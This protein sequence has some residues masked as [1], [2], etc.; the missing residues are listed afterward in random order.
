[1]DVTV[2]ILVGSL[3]Q[4]S[5]QLVLVVVA[6]SE[7]VLEDR[8]V[9]GVEQESGKPLVMPVQETA[10]GLESGSDELFARYESSLEYIADGLGITPSI[11]LAAGIA[12]RA[13]A[14]DPFPCPTKPLFRD[15]LVLIGKALEG[16]VSARDFVIAHDAQ[17]RDYLRVKASIAF[18]TKTKVP[19]PNHWVVL[20]PD[21]RLLTY[22]KVLGE[23]VHEY[24][25]ALE[26]AVHDLVFT[27]VLDIGDTTSGSFPK[28]IRI[29]LGVSRIVDL[30]HE[31]PVVWVTP[32]LETLEVLG[33]I[34]AFIVGQVRDERIIPATDTLVFKRFQFHC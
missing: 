17:R 26:G 30:R 24:R 4:P 2:L 6:A 9:V 8:H 16:D 34:E 20:I 31:E 23:V 21:Q 18:C 33:G 27:H 12:L 7:A 32:G 1:V 25:D 28:L 22:V 10:D 11:V 15:A 29:L 19:A 13:I 14:V 3:V 5:P